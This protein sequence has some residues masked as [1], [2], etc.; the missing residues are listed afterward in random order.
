MSAIPFSSRK[1]QSQAASVCLA[2][3][4]PGGSLSITPSPPTKK[5][6]PNKNQEKNCQLPKSC[7]AIGFP[8]I[9]F[10]LPPNKIGILWET[11]RVPQNW[12]SCPCISLFPSPS[13]SPPLPSVTL[14]G[15]VPSATGNATA[16]YAYN[17]AGFDSW[18]SDISVNVSVAR[19]TSDILVL[20][21][22]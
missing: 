10:S 19:K 4:S 20:P 7:G 8:L 15:R 13:P 5:L 22:K 12:S 6:T 1:G 16:L 17:P 14:G 2:C 9:F 11:G 3:T 18:I 21:W